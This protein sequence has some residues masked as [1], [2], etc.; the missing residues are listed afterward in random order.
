MTLP[1]RGRYRFGPLAVSSRFPMGLVKA[2]AKLKHYERVV[3]WPRLG[4]L[5]PRWLQLVGANRL[6]RQRQQY[7]QGPIDGDYYGLREWRPGDSRRWIHW[8]TTAKLGKLAVRQFEQMQ[9]QDLALVLDLWQPE[10]PSEE[11]LMRIEIAVGFVATVIDDLSRRGTGR[12][13]MGLAAK[14]PGCWSASVSP[15]FARQALER[16]ALVDAATVNHLGDMLGKVVASVSP[17][18]QTIV[19]S[20]RGNQS[21]AVSRAEMFA[22]RQRYQ[23]VLGQI[24]WLEVDTTRISNIFHWEEITRCYVAG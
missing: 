11:H 17:G 7:R 22:G 13:T 10:Q 5:D 21:D 15:V 14:Q 3:A 20:T 8:R 19:V 24:T 12:V 4:R 16:L 9:D 23:R 1:R 18:T 6:G 2:S